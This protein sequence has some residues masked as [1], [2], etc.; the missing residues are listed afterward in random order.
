MIKQFFYIL[1]IF[2]VISCQNIQPVKNPDNLIDRAK[3]EDILYEIAVVNA[4][5]GYD[6]QKLSKYG[7]TPETYI[8]EKYDIDSLQ[9]VENVSYY[10]SDIEAYKDMYLTIQKRVEGEYEYSDSLV[11]RK[12]FIKDSIRTEEVRESV[13]KRD[14]VR[15]VDSIAGRIDSLK[16]VKIKS[17]FPVRVSKEI[18][19]DSL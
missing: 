1:F 9:F 19:I 3:M 10:S 6:I 17:R 15:K 2:F 4:A 11:K 16:G 13:R 8:F 7:V 18:F 12:K 5:R 14:S